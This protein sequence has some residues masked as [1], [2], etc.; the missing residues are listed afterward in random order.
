MLRNLFYDIT[1]AGPSTAK[2]SS[3][4][5][6]NQQRATTPTS[7]PVPSTSKTTNGPAVPP[8]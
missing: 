3:H 2:D 6:N 7:L 1:F 5:A 8:R 4:Q